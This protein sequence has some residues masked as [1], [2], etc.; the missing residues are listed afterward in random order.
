MRNHRS[1]SGNLEFDTKNEEKILANRRD[2]KG[3]NKTKSL[4]NY[5]SRVLF[6]KS[7]YFSCSGRV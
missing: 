5:Y 2:I 6:L 3:E 7:K 4:K 1:R